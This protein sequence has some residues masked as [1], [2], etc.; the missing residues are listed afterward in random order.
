MV[1]WKPGWK[2]THRALDLIGA[3]WNV[4]EI[5]RRIEASSVWVINTAVA[6]LYYISMAVTRVLQRRSQRN[7]E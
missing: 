1:R 2:K 6:L 5:A 4:D 3:R 7:M